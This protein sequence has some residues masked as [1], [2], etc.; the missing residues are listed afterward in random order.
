[1]RTNRKYFSQGNSHGVM[2]S[3]VIFRGVKTQ[4][5]RSLPAKAQEALRLRVVKAVRDGL[6]QTEAARLFGV[7]R[8]TVNGWMDLWAQQGSRALRA[9][10]RGRPPKPRLAL[11]KVQTTVQLI[12]SRYPDQLRL[13]FTLWTREAVQQ[14]LARRFG[15]EVSVWTVG[16]Y[17]RTWGLTRRSRCDGL[18]NK[19]RLPCG[20]G[21]RR[22]TQPFGSKRTRD[23]LTSSS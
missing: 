11:E 4:D 1:M 6:T 9:R 13:P 17:L 15:L 20:N 21:W 7:A 14:L 12:L 10:R 5:A 18:M 2:P 19:A 23:T 22:N 3:A 8:G 16:R